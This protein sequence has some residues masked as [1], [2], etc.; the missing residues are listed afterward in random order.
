MI[1]YEDSI[2]CYTLF[3]SMIQILSQIE[4]Q[5]KH[6]ENSSRRRFTWNL[7]SL[8][9]RKL[10]LQGHGPKSMLILKDVLT[11]YDKHPVLSAWMGLLVGNNT[12]SKVL[13]RFIILHL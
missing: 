13:L 7:L 4:N 5:W 1:V 9:E 3:I 8:Q 10:Y 12:G 11:P 2:D 6:L